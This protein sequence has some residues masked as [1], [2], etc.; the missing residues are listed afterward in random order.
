VGEP[1][2]AEQA[3]QVDLALPTGLMRC[4]YHVE[5]ADRRIG[6]PRG[7]LE[8]GGPVI[9]RQRTADLLRA[10][11]PAPACTS[12]AS[13]FARLHSPQRPGRDVYVELDGCTRVLAMVLPGPPGPL[14]APR[15]VVVG[16]AGPDLRSHL[17]TE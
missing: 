12:T 17:E 16:G 7:S 5:P 1:T 15:L 4:V 9:D 14:V 10:H 2:A 11:G 8:R 13:R 3:E 6:P